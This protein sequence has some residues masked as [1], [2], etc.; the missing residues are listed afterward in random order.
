MS[1]ST[2][3]R[4]ALYDRHQGHNGRIVD[5]AGWAMPIQYSTIVEEH[6]AVR[7]RVGLFDIGH[8]GRLS[9][10]GRDVLDLLE[11]A[12]TNHVAKLEPGRIQYSLMVDDQGGVIDDILV[13]RLTDGSYSIV[14][15]ASNRM[16]VIERIEELRDARDAT[17]IDRTLETAMIAVQ[18][19]ASL[20]VLSRLFDAPLSDL[21]YYHCTSGRILEV[22]AIASRTGYTGEDGFEVVVPHEAAGR[23]WDALLDTGR[24]F[25]ILP[26]GLAARDTLRFEAGMPLYGHEMD[27]TVTPFD[28]GLGWAVKLGKGEFAGRDALVAAKAAPRKHRIGLRLEGKRIARQGAS[29]LAD[30]GPAGLVTSGTFSPTLEQSLAMALVD[31][32]LASRPMFDVD[33]RGRIEVAQVVPL[34]FYK[35]TAPP[36]DDVR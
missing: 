28:T 22:E 14:C 31:S 1:D 32:S 8:M 2:G 13:Y 3:L 27:R 15:N 10:S 12:T 16:A 5:F 29:V 7:R 23:V 30:G 33:V 11:H 6:H 19:P 36:T 34:P 35:R 24:V 9:F 17:L 20:A 21:P 26:C 18:G 4:T 25:G